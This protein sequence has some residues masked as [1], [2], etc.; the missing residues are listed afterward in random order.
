MSKK[1]KMGNSNKKESKQLRNLGIVKIAKLSETT[2][3][4]IRFLSEIFNCVTPIDL[5]L[6]NSHYGTIFQEWICYC[7]LFREIKEGAVYP[8]YNIT[9]KLDENN[10]YRLDKVE[11]LK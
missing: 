1:N 11:E 10:V 3:S 8:Q 2:E 6:N 4:N 7:P 9:V 5:I